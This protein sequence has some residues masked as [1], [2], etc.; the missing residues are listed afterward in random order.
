MS[1]MVN[2]MSFFSHEF[3]E[4]RSADCEDNDGFDEDDDDCEEEEEEEGGNEELNYNEGNGNTDN[5][6]LCVNHSVND[7]LGV[8]S[9][10]YLGDDNSKE[11]VEE[12]EEH[13]KKD[14]D[15]ENHKCTDESSKN[16]EH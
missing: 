3:R 9:N 14:N 7:Y 5:D 16:G 12:V 1:I 8:T 4:M 15:I 2:T 13:K 11:G 6:N 10:K